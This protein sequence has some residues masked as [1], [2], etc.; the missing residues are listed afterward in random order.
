MSFEPPRGFNEGSSSWVNGAVYNADKSSPA[1]REH[2][3]KH[4]WALVK[5]EESIAKLKRNIWRTPT[6][7]ELV[8]LFLA[9]NQSDVAWDAFIRGP[10]A[11]SLWPQ[12]AAVRGQSY[13]RR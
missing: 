1:V 12:M 10:V 6:R 11:T 4:L 2:A 13:W 9:E 7:T 8:R 5:K 3:L